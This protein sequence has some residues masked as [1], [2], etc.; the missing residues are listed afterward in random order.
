[1]INKACN[2][3]SYLF[4]SG[5]QILIDANI[6]LYL[7]PAPGDPMQTCAQ[8][9]STA[10]FKLISSKAQPVLDPIILSEYL[11]RYCR[12]EWDGNFRLQYPSFKQFR[13][14]S[15]FKTVA[16][17]AQTFAGRILGFCQIHSVSPEELDL[18]RALTDFTS[19]QIDFNDAILIDLCKKR[20]M[21]LMTHDSDFNHGGIVVLTTNPKLLRACS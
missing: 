14:S 18:Y 6:W 12:I 9:Y 4:V 2:L 11:N 15:D 20:N 13:K 3:D 19:G 5:E 1:M 21:K 7:F 16:L 8:K 10:F 17:S